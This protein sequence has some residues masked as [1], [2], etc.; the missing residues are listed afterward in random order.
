MYSG[1]AVKIGFMVLTKIKTHFTR[2]LEL[3]CS[4][5]H[6]LDGKTYQAISASTEDE[7]SIYPL[8]LIL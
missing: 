7:E 6:L 1:N 2:I 3:Y 8:C 4:V 5:P